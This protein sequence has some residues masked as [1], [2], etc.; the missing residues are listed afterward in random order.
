MLAFSLNISEDSDGNS[1]WLKTDDA[2]A[3][4]FNDV[5]EIDTCN[6]LLDKNNYL[7][8]P[9]KTYFCVITFVQIAHIY[10]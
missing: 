3:H 9:Q 8:I 1:K 4:W 5:L 6:S 2:I 10:R 7:A